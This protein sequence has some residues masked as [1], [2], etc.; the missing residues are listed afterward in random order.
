MKIVGLKIE[1]GK[2]AVSVIEKGL[3]QT[4]L[5]ESYSI[6]FATDTELADILRTKSR[7][8]TDARIISSIPGNKFSQRTLMFPFSDRKRVEQALPFEMEDVIPFPIDDVELD[9]I[10]LERAETGG[11]KKKDSAVL[12]IVLPKAILRQHLDVLGSMGLDPQVIIPSYIGLFRVAKMIPV[13]GAAVL[14]DGNDICLKIA[15]S[16]IACR[17][18]S[19]S[20]STGGIR[21]T[22]KAFETEQGTPIEKAYLLSENNG[23]YADLAELGIATEKIAPD[24]AGKKPA[25]PASLGIALSE[26][27]NFRKGEFAYRLADVGARKKRLTL[28]IAG[29]FAVVLV[30]AN[31]GVKYYLIESR[32]AK[33]DREIKEIYRQTAPESKS[34]AD[35][36]RQ[37]HAKLDEAKKKFGA[38]GSGTSALDVM[39]AVTDGIP[40]EVRVTFQD[41]LLEG[42]HLKLQGEAA[43]FESIDKMKAELQK[44]GAF[45]EVQ[46]LD[47]RM[48]VDNKVKFRFDLKLK[49]AV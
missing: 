18:F 5:T 12:G 33:L 45:A 11:D 42:D 43:S 28:I 30:A 6:P 25:D 32:F 49:Q 24:F 34:A 38:L 41:F 48:G 2:L 35:P 14:I 36:V 22:I 37:L 4:E 26:H 8:W 47:T 31:I 27:I 40:K 9:H 15:N 10:V 29:A 13:E 19:S 17:S 7:D 3:R 16:V 23:L 1:K 39:K 44:A 21:H 20:Q 46:V